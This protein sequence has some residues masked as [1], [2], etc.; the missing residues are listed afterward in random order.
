[1]IISFPFQV[2]AYANV[3][4]YFWLK[5][6]SIEDLILIGAGSGFL[7]LIFRLEMY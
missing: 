5:N 7:S 6:S 3:F 4:L 2:K 1:M